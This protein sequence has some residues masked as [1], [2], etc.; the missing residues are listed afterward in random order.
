MAMDFTDLDD[1]SAD[2]SSV[3]APLYS[4]LAMSSNCSTDDQEYD[5]EEE[6]PQSHNGAEEQ[7]DPTG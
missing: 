6:E 5:S 2:D 7:D 3:C 4:P 1:Q